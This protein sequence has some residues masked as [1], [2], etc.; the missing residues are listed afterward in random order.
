MVRNTISTAFL[1]AMCVPAFALPS[2]RLSLDDFESASAIVVGR[3][4]DARRLDSYTYTA[5]LRVDR[6]LEGVAPG[7]PMRILWEQPLAMRPPNLLDGDDV[8]VAARALAP[9]PFANDG[10]GSD[11][12]GL[13]FEIAAGGAAY[14][15]LPDPQSLYLLDSYLS[16][17]RE[18]RFARLGITA[19]VRLTASAALPLRKAA[20]DRLARIDGLDARLSPDARQMLLLVVAS[21]D[22]PLEIR[23]QILTLAGRRK[24]RRLRKDLVSLLAS[25]PAVEPEVLDAIAEM[26]GRLPVELAQRSLARQSAAVRAAAVRGAPSAWI[27]DRLPALLRSDPAPKVRAEAARALAGSGA[28]GRLRIAAE[29]LWDVDAV[30]R[31]AAARAIGSRGESAV[32]L[33]EHVVWSGSVGPAEAA[34]LGLAVAGRPGEPALREILAR[35]PSPKM[36]QLAWL[37]LARF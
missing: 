14:V 6:V 34:L 33:L 18:E 27:D 24:L 16:L 21:E 32:L 2:E 8:L 22:Q 25:R 17:P 36:R 30:V 19:L 23:R 4:H 5:R 3:V 11:M 10:S 37:A 26:D 20:L 31:S 28:R 29:G 7:P 9:G 35:Y 1:L 12:Q 15:R 13:V